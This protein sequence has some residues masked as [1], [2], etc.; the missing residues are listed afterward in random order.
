MPSTGFDTLT[1]AR[2]LE[3]AGVERPQAEAIAAQLRAA[4]SAD[5]DGLA[6]KTDLAALENH[7][8]EPEIR[9]VKWAIG[10]AFTGSAVVLVGVRL[11]LGSGSG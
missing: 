1:A 2:E 7:L 5:R 8:V 6:T 9:L 3:T 10:L 4:A 11:M